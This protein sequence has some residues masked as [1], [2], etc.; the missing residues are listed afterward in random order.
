MRCAQREH[1]RR[2]H[3]RSETYRVMDSSV[4]RSAAYACEKDGRDTVHNRARSV[5]PASDERLPMSTERSAGETIALTPS[6]QAYFVPAPGG[7]APGIVVIQEAFGVNAFVRGTCDRLAAAGYAVI[8][9]DYYHGRTYDYADRERA[10]AAAHGIDD[11]EAMQ[12]TRLALD[13][14]CSQAGAREDRLA[15]IGFCMGGR[16]AFLANAT[17]GRRLAATVSFYGGGI[18]PAQP[19]KRKSLLDRAAD[20]AAPA[21]MIYGAGDAAIT[22]DEHARL[23]HALTEANKRYVLAVFPDAPHA[24]ATFDRDSYRPRAAADAWRLVD[25]F[26]AA[27][28][29]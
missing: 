8:A 3:D 17:H 24:F 28:L 12:E 5:S 29:K 27:E 7:Y 1:L 23:A 2:R 16:L 6:L 9:P 11:I 26:L 19:G 14:L 4:K 22:A 15:V 18:A 10:I 25:A 20:L 21:L 13:A